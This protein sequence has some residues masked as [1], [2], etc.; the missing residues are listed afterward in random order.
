LY[1][2]PGQ[3]IVALRKAQGLTQVQLAE[4]LGVAQ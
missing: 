1:I 3:R 2:D 4:A